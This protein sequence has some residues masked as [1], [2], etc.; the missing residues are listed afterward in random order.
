MSR[1]TQFLSSFVGHL[2]L[3]FASILALYTLLGFFLVPHLA[4]RQIQKIV[5]EKLSV[6]PHIQKITFNP[7]TFEMS[8]ANFILPNSTQSEKSRLQF[9]KLSVNLDIFPLLKKEIHFQSIDLEKA[10]GQ[11]VI[12][13]DRSTN[14]HMKESPSEKKDKSKAP[15]KWVLKIEHI[16]LDESQF[17][18]LDE[19]HL[20]PLDLPLGPVSLRASNISTSFGSES[21]LDNLEFSVGDKGHIKLA[22]RFDVKPVKADIQIEM[23]DAPMESLTA[24]LSDKTYLLLKQATANVAG[25]LKYEDGQMSFTG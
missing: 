15:S 7:F 6:T 13:K 1:F 4:Q 8:I 10:D 9:A 18:F 17:D 12:F 14:W 21:S 20:R 3:T 19:T 5:Q 2:L 11:L 22:G 25:N 24:Y 23:S 16:R